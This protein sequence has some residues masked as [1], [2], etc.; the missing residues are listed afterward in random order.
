MK[1]V[2][3]YTAYKI[4]FT[5]VKEV[6]QFIRIAN[7]VDYSIDLKQSHYCVNASS[8]VGIFA[9]D[10]ENEVIMFVPTEHEKNAEKMFAEFIIK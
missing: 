8:I 5:T 10:L 9:L 3:E 4:R 1:M 2:T 7:M 6:Q